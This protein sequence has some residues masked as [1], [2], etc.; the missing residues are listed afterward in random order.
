M[1]P[2]RLTIPAH[3]I[4]SSTYQVFAR[5]GSGEL[6]MLPHSPSLQGAFDAAEAAARAGKTILVRMVHHIPAYV[7]PCSV[8]DVTPKF[9]DERMGGE[10]AHTPRTLVDLANATS[11]T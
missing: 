4:P 11:G 1:T 7:G 9:L 3:V 6:E 8:I 5:D 2:A 10:N